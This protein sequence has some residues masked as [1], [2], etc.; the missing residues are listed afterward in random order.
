MATHSTKP[1]KKSKPQQVQNI[2]FRSFT[3]EFLKQHEHTTL[4]DFTLIK[5]HGVSDF[6]M[7]KKMNREH[8]FNENLKMRIDKAERMD[9]IRKELIA[10]RDEIEKDSVLDIYNVYTK[11]IGEVIHMNNMLRANKHLV[12]EDAKRDNA[13]F[14]V[15][16]VLNFSPLDFPA[17]PT[18]SYP[19]KLDN[20]IKKLLSHTNHSDSVCRQTNLDTC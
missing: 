2:D 6:Y 1:V 20:L 4:I 17:N 19:A 18:K 15:L 12:V 14:D 9:Y 13:P 16:E 8:D 11:K 10:I 7:L 5:D 3:K